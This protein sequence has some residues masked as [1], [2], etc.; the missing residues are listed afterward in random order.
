MLLKLHKI[1]TPN[2]FKLILK[3]L[4]KHGETKMATLY[5]VSKANYRN[6][7]NMVYK[8]TVEGFTEVRVMVCCGMKMV[9]LVG[10]PKTLN[11]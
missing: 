1:Q 5:L 8:L 11:L 10:Q 2:F 6:T 4:Q 9:R 3:Y 7:R